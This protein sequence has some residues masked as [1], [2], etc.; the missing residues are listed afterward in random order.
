MKFTLEEWSE[1]YI[2]SVAKYA[3]N[4]KLREGSEIPF[5][6]PIRKKMRNGS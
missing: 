2:P 1:A 6:I 5:P 4:E 3:N